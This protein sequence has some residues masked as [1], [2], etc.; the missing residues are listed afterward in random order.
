MTLTAQKKSNSSA[1][2][3]ARIVPDQVSNG[4]GDKWTEGFVTIR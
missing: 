3:R 2:I 1:Y 4:H